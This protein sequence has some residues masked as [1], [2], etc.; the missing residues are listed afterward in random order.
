MSSTTESF[1]Q[2]LREL[3][4]RHFGPRGKADFARRLQLTAD[5][6]DKLERG[7]VPPGDLI[8]RICEATGEDLQWL[9]TGVAARGTVV[10][11]GARGRH[12]T[13]LADIAALLDSRPELSSPI[14]AFVSLLQRGPAP[15]ASRGPLPPPRSLIPLLGPRAVSSLGL[16][17]RAPE[18]AA[19]VSLDP[20]DA[21]KLRVTR[22]ARLLELRRVDAE[23]SAATAD[24][25][26]ELSGA[27]DTAEFLDQP[28][29]AET[30]PGVFGVWLDT[31][32][33]SPMFEP[34]DAALVCPTAPARVG[35]PALCS[36]VDQPDIRCRMWLGADET[37]AL[38]LGRLGD[39]AR[40]SVPAD[41]VTWSL[42]V[43]YRLSPA[44]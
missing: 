27:D 36:S 9:L 12:Q 15:G 16:A 24:V 29:L 28:Q 41:H 13:L 44:A 10:I 43:L 42:E 30:F 23:A 39:G 18:Q 22:H 25:L 7:H 17:A 40:E 6:Y 34:G 32:D 21:A 3:R 31:S 5:D 1:A 14:E 2:R 37:G 26:G 33:M 20:A 4:R 8:I 11:S 19:L 35:R 38:Q